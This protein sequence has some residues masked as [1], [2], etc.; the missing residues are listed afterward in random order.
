MKE[1]KLRIKNTKTFNLIIQ[2]TY[3]ERILTSLSLK[4]TSQNIESIESR[5]ISR[6]INRQTLTDAKTKYNSKK[7]LICI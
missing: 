2:V 3:I 5:N 4:N 6:R 1:I 7:R